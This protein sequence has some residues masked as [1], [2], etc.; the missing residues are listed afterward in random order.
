M[1]PVPDPR[2]HWR[3]CRE[4]EIDVAFFVWPWRLGIDRTED[5]FGGRRTIAIGPIGF[6]ITYS[7]GN[8]SREPWTIFDRIANATALGEDE[9]YCR[10]TRWEGYA[11][12]AFDEVQ[13]D[14]SR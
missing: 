13:N 12:P 8:P 4:F 10:A 5:V 3:N 14:R 7:H 6:G 11:D 9:A 2:W 1:M